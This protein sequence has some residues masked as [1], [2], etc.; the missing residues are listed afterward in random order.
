MKFPTKSLFCVA[1]SLLASACTTQD[2]LAK[3]ALLQSTYLERG[4]VVNSLGQLEPEMMNDCQVDGYYWKPHGEFD[5]N[6]ISNHFSIHYTGMMLDVIEDDGD[7][8]IATPQSAFMEPRNILTDL[9]LLNQTLAPSM[10]VDTKFMI[11][12][13][14]LSTHKSLLALSEVI[15]NSHNDKNIIIIAT[16]EQQKQLTNKLPSKT[17]IL[18]EMPKSLSTSHLGVLSLC[19]SLSD[20]LITGS[21][22]SDKTLI[23]RLSMSSFVSF[24][25]L[26]Q[27]LPHD[28]DF[29]DLQQQQDLWREGQY[30]LFNGQIAKLSQEAAA[31]KQEKIDSGEIKRDQEEIKLQEKITINTTQ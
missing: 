31:Y 29:S 20:E 10:K 16:V 4:I 30:Q 25:E 5:Q 7:L 17:T 2:N 12:I 14:K 11:S 15:K 9:P 1:L 28:A 21:Y 23:K 27:T 8:Y 3:S 18:S 13:A 6:T 19:Q 24:V 22:V 26:V